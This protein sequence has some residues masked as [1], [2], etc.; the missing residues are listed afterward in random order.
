VA[1]TQER[2]AWAIDDVMKGKICIVTGGNTGIGKATVEGLA[3]QGATV[4]LACRDLSKGRAALDDI[5]AKTGSTELHLLQLDLASLKSVRAFAKAFTDKFPRL[6]VLLENAG[7][8][9]SKRQLTED[10][11]EMDFGVNHLGHFLLA[12]LLLPTLKASAPSRIVVVSSSVHKGAKLDFDDLQGDKSWGGMRFYGQSKLANMLFVR[13]LS[14]RLEG[15]GVVV[16]GLHPGVI[17]TELARDFPAPLRLIAKWFFKSTEQGARTSLYLAT[18]PEAGKVSGKYF[19]DS[20]E[21]TPDPRVLDDP[22][23]ERLWSESAR[24]I[25]SVPG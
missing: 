21:A 1:L 3:R 6:D 14:K 9:T 20:K 23:A 12:E 15:T 22:F 2:Y 24:L 8:S 17:A 16:N 19:A 10:G 25:A 7:V 4:V 5:K 11:F 18:A 13:S